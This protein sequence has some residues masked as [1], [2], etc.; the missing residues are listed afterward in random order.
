MPLLSSLDF[1]DSR[2]FFKAEAVNCLMTKGVEDSGIVTMW[3]IPVPV[4]S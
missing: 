3:I 1:E 4:L 2:Y